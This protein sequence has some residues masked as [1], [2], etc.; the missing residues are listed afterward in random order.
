[1]YPLLYLWRRIRDESGA[2]NHKNIFQHW[3]PRSITNPAQ[4]PKYKT[5]AVFSILIG[6]PVNLITTFNKIKIVIEAFT[7]KKQKPGKNW[8]CNIFKY[9]SEKKEN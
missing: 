7:R 5:L 3:F 1:V 8:R 6:Q 4:K 9:I 2:V